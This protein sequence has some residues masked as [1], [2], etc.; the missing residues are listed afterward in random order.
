MQLLKKQDSKKK[1]LIV[2]TIAC[3]KLLFVKWNKKNDKLFKVNKLKIATLS[4]QSNLNK[5]LWLIS[6]KNI[7]KIIFALQK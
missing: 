7:S 4:N 2:V 3:Q 6:T 5:N 1:K